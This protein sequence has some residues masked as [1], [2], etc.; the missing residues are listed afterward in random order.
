MYR[1]RLTLAVVRLGIVCALIAMVLAMALLSG[2]V[3]IVFVDREEGAFRG[4]SRKV[5]GPDR[6]YVSWLLRKEPVK[7]PAVYRDDLF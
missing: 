2:L 1:S 3:V 4:K 5:L 7:T 6:P